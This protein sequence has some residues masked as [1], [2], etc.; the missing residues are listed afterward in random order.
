M[1][2]LKNAARFLL[3]ADGT[4]RVRTIRSGIW[5]SFAS[6]VIRVLEFVRSIVLARLLV[7]ELF[8]VMAIVL[9][10]RG[11]VDVVTSTSFKSALIYKQEDIEETANT[12]WTL[13]IIRGVFLFVLMLVIAPYVSVFYN[14]PSLNFAIRF[15]AFSLL[16]E[17]FSNINT[18]ILEK[19][20]N[21]RSITT[22]K[23]VSSFI[24]I[25][26]VL[27]LAY[28]YQ[29]IWSLLIGNF[30]SSC[31]NVISTYIIQPKKPK[32]KFN[33]TVAADLFQYAKYV[34]GTGI[35]VFFTL[36]MADIVLGK[37]LSLKELGYYSYAFT[38]A[39]LPTTHITAVVSEI[40]FSAYN[41]IKSDVAKLKVV[42]LKI[43]RIISI[44]AVPAGVGIYAL[45]DE[46]IIVML[47]PDWQPAIAPLRVLVFF[48][49]IRSLAATTGPILTAVGKP[50]VVFWI[51]FS[52][53]CFIACLIY[54]SIKYYGTVGAAFSLTAPIAIE[55]L[56]LWYIIKKELKISLLPFLHSVVKA[57]G[58]S[59]IMLLVILV[60]KTLMPINS[61][62]SLLAAISVG[63]AAY[64][65]M[66]FN[67]ENKIIQDFYELKG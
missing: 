60:F 53:F 64:A 1:E 21:Y 5:I 46:I 24:N 66:T 51:V 41:A 26:V 17:S 50:K 38:L 57:L 40:I 59:L 39:N 65:L 14:E 67:F 6:A 61:V 47:G 42:F 9:C 35:L 45:A 2:M 44:V 36:T 18:V 33:K 4:V 63:I 20:L 25:T 52:K 49:V 3:D 11:A 32:F 31:F 28:V 55:Q 58:F 13:N 43:F 12:A 15:I 7:P 8:G 23:I 54:P 34:T 22:A 29:N 27:L 48:G 30:L 37:L 56:L 19:S 62:I 16:V 10:V